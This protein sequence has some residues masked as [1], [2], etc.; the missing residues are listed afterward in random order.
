VPED[1]HRSDTSEAGGDP[2]RVVL[3]CSG[4]DHVQRGFE[5]FARECFEALRDQPGIEIRLVKGSGPPRDRERSIPTLRSD[6][7]PA[8]AIGRLT[9]RPP[10]FAEHVTFALS[11]IPLLARRRPDVVY[12]SEWWVGRVLAAWRRFGRGRWKLV[13]SNG[14][15]APGPYPHLDHV[16]QLVPGALDAVVARGVSAHN[17]SVLPLGVAMGPALRRTSPEERAQLRAT[18]GLPADRR[19]LVSVGAINRQKRHSYVID[20]VASL[21]EPRPFL[22]LAGQREAETPEV[23][24]HAAARLGAHGHKILTV[25]SE[26]MPDVYRASDAFVLASLWEGSPRALVEAL[27]HGLP[28]L[29]H[30]YP[31]MIWLMGGHGAAADFTQPGALAGLLAGLRDDDLGEPAREARH[32][33]VHERF[34]WDSLA[35]RYVEFLRRVAA[36]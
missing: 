2:P 1:S 35:P 6:T 28:C 24:T 31:V 27:S 23:E 15:L 16:Q 4:L 12:F 22:L 8:R 19:I 25:P 17:Q 18:L 7:A 9:R 34:S 36:E 30:D 20:E 5:T 14:S 21:P 32:A 13:L 3:A 10:F 26:R 33:S 11:L 29:T